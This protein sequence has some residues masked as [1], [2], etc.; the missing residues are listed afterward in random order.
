MCKEDIRIGREKYS[1]VTLVPVPNGSSAIA[2]KPSNERTHLAIYPINSTV[3]I[4]PTKD[5][6]GSEIGYQ[7]APAGHPFE[8]DIEIHGTAVTQGWTFNNQALVDIVVM[9]IETF[10]RD[11]G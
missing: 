3:G 1:A 10:W 7:L 2:C 8:L 11:R 6:T 4:V 5:F 9:V